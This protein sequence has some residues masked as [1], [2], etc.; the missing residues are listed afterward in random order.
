[1]GRLAFDAVYDV[2]TDGLVHLGAL[3]LDAMEYDDLAIA[4]EHPALHSDVRT[5]AALRRE[6]YA[7]RECGD[8]ARA[9]RL[10]GKADSLY[11]LMPTSVQW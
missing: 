5:Y 9:M 1:M 10:E 3:N 2:R 6:A 8:I 11:D 7:L 4:S